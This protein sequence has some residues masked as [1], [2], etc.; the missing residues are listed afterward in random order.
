M[1][2]PLHWA[3]IGLVGCFAALLVGGLTLATDAS[4]PASLL[5]ALGGGGAA[6]MG[7]ATLIG[8]QAE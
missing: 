3:V 1:K 8:R 2:L 5:A 6:V 7:S 4:W